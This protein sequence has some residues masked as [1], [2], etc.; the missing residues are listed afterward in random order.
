MEYQVNM[1][2]LSSRKNRRVLSI[3]GRATI[4]HSG[5]DEISRQNIPSLAY[6]E[7]SGR[8]VDV[9]VKFKEPKRKDRQLEGKLDVGDLTY[10]VTLDPAT[11]D[12]AYKDE[13]DVF[14]LRFDLR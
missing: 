8:V 3:Q 11:Y 13:L 12:V 10:N 14:Y 7:Y 5:S 4:N 6:R 1:R 2:D 9:V